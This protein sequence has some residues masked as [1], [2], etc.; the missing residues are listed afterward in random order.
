MKIGTHEHWSGDDATHPSSAPQSPLQAGAVAPQG[1]MIVVFVV[2]VVVV[3]DAT[4][5]NAGTQSSL[6]ARA[7]STAS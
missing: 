3:A 4:S 1:G 7:T 5:F 6:A 2:V